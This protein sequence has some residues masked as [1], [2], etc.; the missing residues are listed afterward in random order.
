M[1]NTELAIMELQ[2]YLRN[3]SLLHDSIPLLVSNGI[4]CE[5]TAEAVREFQR[6]KGLPITGAVDFE[7]WKALVDTSKSTTFETS[8]PVQVIK[9]TND[10]LPLVLGMQNAFVKKLKIMLND[11]A[12]QSDDFDEIKE[13]DYFDEKTQ[14]MVTQ[15]QKIISAEQN[16]IVDKFTWNSLSNFYLI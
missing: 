5:K 11:V 15:W 3:I 12:R 1:D 10:D 9:I 8:Q 4:Y 7:T 13:D 16:G 14:E 2:R 6:I